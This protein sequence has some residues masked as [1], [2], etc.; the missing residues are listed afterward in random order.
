M[1]SKTNFKPFT[2]DLRINTI[3]EAF[4]LYHRLN[5]KSTWTKDCSEA[6]DYAK[7]YANTGMTWEDFLR[8][9]NGS[10]GLWHQLNRELLS[11]GISISAFKVE[12]PIEIGGHTAKISKNEVTVGCTTVTKD[13]LKEILARM[14]AE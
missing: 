1:S 3:E 11:N 14:E 2:L 7:C 5:A 9:V 8:V 13:T 10:S 12:K 4:G 6:V